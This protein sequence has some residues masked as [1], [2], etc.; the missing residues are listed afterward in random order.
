MTLDDHFRDQLS[1]GQPPLIALHNAA[2]AYAASMKP[3][4]CA[5]YAD[6]TAAWSDDRDEQAIKNLSDQIDEMIFRIDHGGMQ[7]L[8]QQHERFRK[9]VEKWS[10]PQGDETQDEP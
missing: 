7:S 8:V 3:R 5:Q 2:Q 9:F 4:D 1:R 10:K 6:E